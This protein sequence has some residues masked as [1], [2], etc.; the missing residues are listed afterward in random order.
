MDLMEHNALH[1]YLYIISA[2]ALGN[3]EDNSKIIACF[4]AT[5]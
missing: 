1:T 3:E 4:N 2:L 5:F